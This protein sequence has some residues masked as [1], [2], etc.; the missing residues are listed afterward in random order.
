MNISRNTVR[1]AIFA[2]ALAAFA[3]TGLTAT[4]PA[5]E[6]AFNG[7]CDYYDSQGN[8]VGRFGKDCCGNPIAWGVRTDKANC[9]VEVCVWC[10]P[11]S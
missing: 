6:A 5:T 11:V 3:I 2:L 9:Y 7:V 8:Q 1:R 10:P 4:A